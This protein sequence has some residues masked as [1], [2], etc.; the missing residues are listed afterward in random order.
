MNVRSML[1]IVRLVSEGVG[2]AKGIRDLARRVKNN[3]VISDK[4]INEARA[5]INTAVTGWNDSVAAN[6]KTTAKEVTNGTD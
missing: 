5:E 6:R 4:D 1:L 3:E 2:V